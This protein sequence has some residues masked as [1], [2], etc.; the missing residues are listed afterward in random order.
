[1]L[2]I[3]HLLSAFLSVVILGLSSCG[4]SSKD[5]PAPAPVNLKATTRKP[6][7]SPSI[8][9]N[10]KNE[11]AKSTKKASGQSTKA[12]IGGVKPN[13]STP[14]SNA[15]VNKLAAGNTTFGRT[16]TTTATSAVAVS[17][18][19]INT[20]ALYDEA[21]SSALILFTTDATLMDSDEDGEP[22]TEDT[23]DD[24]D[25]TPDTEDTDDDNDGVLDTADDED[26]D[27]DGILDADDLDDDGDGVTDDEE[28]E[29]ATASNTDSDDDGIFDDLDNDDDGDGSY[30]R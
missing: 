24:N 3:K 5:N 9:T 23:D 22:D 25:G 20:V 13:F 17:G 19:A 8:E 28:T 10:V 2:S 18:W 15:K 1:M 21:D 4:D 11:P 7:S 16:A 30:D 14:T 12:S 29:T 26:D 27:N 6:S